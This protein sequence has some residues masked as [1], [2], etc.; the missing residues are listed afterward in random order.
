MISSRISAPPS[1]FLMMMSCGK[2]EGGMGASESE[3]E[4]GLFE[5]Q[6]FAHTCHSER[7]E[8]SIMMYAGGCAAGFFATLR[9]T[10]NRSWLGIRRSAGHHA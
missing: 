7:S 1:R 3:S 4:S 8:E 6:Q 10:V 9:M 2:K 5:K